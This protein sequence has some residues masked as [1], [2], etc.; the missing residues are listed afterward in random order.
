[1]GLPMTVW[2]KSY[3]IGNRI[4]TTF[5]KH[6]NVMDLKVWRIVRAANKWCR[7][8]AVLTVSICT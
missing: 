5:R 1:M 6:F 3:C 8:V 4:F 7:I 2:T